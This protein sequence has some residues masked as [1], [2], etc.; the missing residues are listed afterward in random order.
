M[1]HTEED[2]RMIAFFDA[3]SDGKS[4]YNSKMYF[5]EEASR[6]QPEQE[7]SAA[8]QL[9]TPSQQQVDQA[10]MQLKRKLAV[11]IPKARKKRRVVKRVKKVK[12]RTTQKKKK[13]GK[14]AVKKTKKGVKKTAKRRLRW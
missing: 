5:L 2:K 3:L 11:A 7:G 9:V 12:R 14:K 10:K 1:E 4:P 8:I 6:Q 13:P